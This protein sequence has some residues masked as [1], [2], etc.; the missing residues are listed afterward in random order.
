M[1]GEMITSATAREK[2]SDTP[3]CSSF[4]AKL[5]ERRRFRKPP[6]QLIARSAPGPS[7]R[8]AARLQPKLCA[9]GPSEEGRKIDRKRHRVVS[10]AD[11]EEQQSSSDAQ[12]G[13][14]TKRPRR[15]SPP[16][17]YVSTS[18]LSSTQLKRQY[19]G[20]RRRILD[21]SKVA[22]TFAHPLV[23]DSWTRPRTPPE[24]VETLFYLKADVMKFRR[25]AWRERRRRSP[26]EAKSCIDGELWR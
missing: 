18:F 9:A 8:T 13:Q 19:G 17:S 2:K 11:N 25:R 16:P 3:K 5:N 12:S 24:D 14:P 7:Y 22:V 26:Q 10:R 23:T 4:V 1:N 21:P 20:L 15:V 6:R